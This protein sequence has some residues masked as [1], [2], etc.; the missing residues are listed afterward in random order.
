[1][2]TLYAKIEFYY[3]YIRHNVH[4]AYCDWLL[5]RASQCALCLL[6]LVVITYFIMYSKYAGIGLYYVRYCVHYVYQ[7][8]VL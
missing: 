1:M 3:Y 2:Y 6:R 5:L 7:Y 4:C 8:W